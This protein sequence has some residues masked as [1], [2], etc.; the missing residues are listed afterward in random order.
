M[1]A[2]ELGLAEAYSYYQTISE[3]EAV[4]FIQV[5]DARIRN[6]GKF[7]A[8]ELLRNGLRKVRLDPYPYYIYYRVEESSAWIGV[9]GIKHERALSKLDE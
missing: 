1:A 8:H 6:L 3:R 5:A 4:R 2:A 7:W 9:V